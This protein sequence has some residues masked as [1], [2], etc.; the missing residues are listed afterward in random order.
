MQIHG[1]FIGGTWYEPTATLPVIDPS[2]GSSFARI[3]RG[4]AAEISAAVTAAHSALDGEWGRLS[5]I[6]RGRLLTRLS[7]LI[8][9]D[10]EKLAGM[11]SQDV[12][13]P[14]REG[15]A[16]AIACARYF[17]FYGGAADKVH[18]DTIP[19]EQGFTVFTHWCRTAS[20]ATSSPGIIRCKSSV[21][22]SV[23]RW[24]WATPAW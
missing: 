21:A 22:P 8:Q 9:R 14:L 1:H 5:A 23:R 3:A 2:D 10:S 19:Y 17:E 7:Q 20:P 24:P 16:D 4:T 6:E 18:G 11:E 13:K 15:R 12:G